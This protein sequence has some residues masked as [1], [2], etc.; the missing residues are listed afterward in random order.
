MEDDKIK[1]LFKEFEPELSSSFQF[2]A[3]LQKNMEA[4][5]IIRR[6]NAAQKRRNKWAV[7]IAGACGFAMGV[8]LTLLFPLILDWVS[9][10]KISLPLISAGTMSIDFSY[11]AWFL[12]AAVSVLTSIS[13]YELASAKLSP[14]LVQ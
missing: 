9:S 11:I 8:I 12:V 6:Y 5:E 2:M 13:V 7:A 4:V 3:K 1:D 14:K 10:I